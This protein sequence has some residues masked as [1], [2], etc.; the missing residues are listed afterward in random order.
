MT[1]SKTYLSALVTRVENLKRDQKAL[2][3]GPQLFAVS[4]FRLKTRL[5]QL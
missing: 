5:S 1:Y 3:R 4:G 2:S